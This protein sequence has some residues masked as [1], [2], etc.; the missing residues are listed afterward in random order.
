MTPRVSH[1]GTLGRI[2]LL[3][4][5]LVFLGAGLAMGYFFVLTDLSAA[6]TARDYVPVQAELLHV[7]L[8]YHRSDKSTTYETKARY[9]YRY[10]ERDYTSE[11]VAIGEGADNIGSY[12]QDLYKRLNTAKQRR[13]TVVAWVNP[14]NPNEALLDRDMRWGLFALKGMFFLVFSLVGLGVTIYTLRAP[15]ALPAAVA[16]K[17]W[18]ADPAWRNG[19]IVSRSR[20]GMIGMW[21]FAVLWNAISAPILFILPAELAKQ[22]WAALLG[23][24]F[25]L[26]GLWLFYVAVLKTLQWRRFGELTLMMHPFPGALGGV[27]GGAV[28]LPE[29]FRPGQTFRISLTCVHRRISNN[30]DRDRSDS[31]VW[32][33]EASAPVET[34][35]RGSRVSFRFAVPADLPPTTAPSESYHYWTVH[36]KAELDGVDLDHSFD[37]PVAASDGVA[38]AATPTPATPTPVSLLAPEI[39]AR[40]VRIERRGGTTVFYYPLFR[41]PSL[42]IGLL[43][44][45]LIFAGSTV[46]LFSQARGGFSGLIAGFMALV[47][48]MIT[49]AMLLLALYCLANTLRVE[50]SA[51]GLT[52]V[53]RVFGIAFTTHVPLDEIAGI[54]TKI[55]SQSRSGNQFSVRYVLHALR[56]AGRRVAVGDDIPGQALADHLAGLLREACGIRT[57]RS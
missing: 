26:V 13:A 40:L 2:G 19:R 53:R 33:S 55:G 45:S 10:A 34:S 50:V 27:V 37:I 12:Q 4:F 36:L 38:V 15:S 24:L 28:E 51:R 52:A 9:R 42:G 35:G 14:G 11:R 3:L 23:L 17:P 49:L 5:G 46:F 39:P 44:F 29:R 54:E 30:K 16:D 25:P 41:Y 7:E 1:Q 56:H 47:F 48:G 8:K 32:Q 20:A 31:A 6:I 57:V 43:I 18:L 21:F 22:N